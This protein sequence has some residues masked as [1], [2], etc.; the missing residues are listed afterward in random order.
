MILLQVEV[1]QSCADAIAFGTFQSQRLQSETFIKT[2]EQYLG[3]G[4]DPHRGLCFL[5]EVF[6]LQGVGAG[7]VIRGWRKDYISKLFV[8]FNAQI[9]PEF[10][11]HFTDV[12]LFVAGRVG[13]YCINI[14]R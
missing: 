4:T 14:Y 9:N 10:V 8:A 6:S 11:S 12:V 1:T 3:T 7:L 2:A 13:K 5:S